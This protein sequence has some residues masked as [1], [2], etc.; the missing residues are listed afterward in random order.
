MSSEKPTR[1]AAALPY[2][3]GKR[4]LK[5]LL[6]TSLETRRWVLP[7]GNLGENSSERDSAV[8]EAYEEAG[9]EGDVARTSIGTY[10]YE[11]AEQKG[12]GLRRVSVFPMAVS[13]VLR[14]WPEKS[15][16]RRKWMT[17]DDAISVVEEA[18]LKKLMSTFRSRMSAG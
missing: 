18:E 16:R 14:N 10:D 8:Q 4:G 9:I 3:K 1:Q 17:I 2:R 6:V 12:G 5:V 13:R 15:R 11:K 7:K